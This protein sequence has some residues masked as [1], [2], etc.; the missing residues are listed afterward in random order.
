M[1]LFLYQKPNRKN[2]TILFVAAFLIRASMFYFFIQHEHRYQQPDSMDYHNSAIGISVGTGMHRPDNNRPIFW[3][4]PGYPLYLSCFYQLCGITSAKL[5]DNRAAHIIALWLQIILSSLL[6]LLIFFLILSLTNNLS[7]A[8]ISGWT[9]AFHLGYVLASTYLLTESLALLFFVPF[10]LFFYK[11]FTAYGE[12]PGKK[13]RWILYT[14]LA[15]LMLGLTTWIRP[16]GEFFSVVASIIIFL[17]A[18][19][20][21]TQKIKQISLFLLIFFAT[22]SGWYVRNYGITGKLFFCPMFGPY[23]NSFCAPKILRDTTPLT[24][25]QAVNFQ[26]RKAT[27]Q[28]TKDAVKA[29]VYGKRECRE[30]AALPVALSVLLK[31]PWIFLRDWI[32]ETIKTTFDLHSH[33]LVRYTNNTF[34]YDDLEEHLSTKLA[35]CLYAAQMPLWMRIIVL[36]EVLYSLFIWIGM[37]LG[38]WLFLLVPLFTRKKRSKKQKALTALWLKIGLMIGAAIV[39]TGGFG[40]ARLRLPIDPFLLMLALTTWLFLFAITKKNDATS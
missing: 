20:S 18:N 21:F 40:Y 4:T 3:R 28:A 22:I 34:F 5:R 32:R 29:H 12:Q 23:L 19:T 35:D 30:R 16:L 38:V 33:L 2:L 25:A 6:P 13:P 8:W 9:F 37:F 1:T 27:E 31:H 15:A 24:L 14:I 26:Y 7:I 17:M 36:L 39:M 10:L 11:S